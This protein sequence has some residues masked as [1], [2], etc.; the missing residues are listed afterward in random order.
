AGPTGTAPVT[1][2]LPTTPVTGGADLIPAPLKNFGITSPEQIT[3]EII[4][5]FPAEGLALFTPE[6]T[7]ALP[8]ESQAALA[9]RLNAPSTPAAPAEIPEALLIRLK[10]IGEVEIGATGG[11]TVTRVNG[12]AS[13]GLEIS[14]DTTGNTVE[15]VDAVQ[16]EFDAFRARPGNEG[17]SVKI[18]AEQGSQITKSVNAVV[19]EGL[20]GAIVAVVII[21]LFLRSTRSTL[22]TA[23]S[24]PLSIVVALILMRL[25]GFS[26]NVMTL[27]GLTVAVGRVIDDS[28]VV[29]ENIYRHIN[30]GDDLNR[31]VI[32][33]TKEVA[34]AIT[35]STITTVCVFLPL[36]LVGGIVSKFFLPFALTVT[37]ALLAS[38]VV[39]LTVI[40]LLARLFLRRSAKP[41]PEETLLQRWYTAALKWSLRYRGATLVIA[42]ALLLASCAAI[43]L[44]KVTFLP[45]QSEKNITLS[46][47]LPAGTNL[48]ATSAKADEIEALI[49]PLQDQGQVRDIQTVV[50]RA[51]GADRARDRSGGAG[52]SNRA[53]FTLILDNEKVADPITL[54]KQIETQVKA[55]PGVETAAAETIAVGGSAPG[56]GGLDITLVSADVDKLREANDK[57]MAAIGGNKAS[58]RFPVANVKSS[59]AEVKPE[60]QVTVDPQKAIKHGTSAAQIALQ[61]RALLAGERAGD[62]T[63]EGQ[64]QLELFVQVDQSD[65][66]IETLRKLPVGTVSPVALEEVAEIEEV[67]GASSITRINGDRAASISGQFTSDNTFQTQDAIEEEISK[68]IGLPEGVLIQ[69]G[70]QAR[71]QTETFANMGL[72][73]LVAI[74]LVYIVMMI[75]FGSLLNP[76]IIL[77]SVL[78]AIIGVVLSLLLTGKPA[79][80]TTMIGLLMLV[81]IV[82]TNGI[83]LVELVEQYREERGMSAYDA[84]LRAGRVRLRPILMTAIATIVALIP[85]ALGLEEG[86]FIG[87]DLGVVVIGGLFT[88]TFLTLLVVPVVYSLLDGLKTRFGF[89]HKP[90]EHAEGEAA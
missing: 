52:A 41:E 68:N 19:S 27:G 39:A 50:G 88:S 55:L 74:M 28:I 90:A 71:S 89:G 86:G 12:E 40:P 25:Q 44:L 14:R 60:L 21:F 81:G 62:V 5:Q 75:S 15:I 53:D 4:N 34:G 9:Q 11:N 43:P 77:C 73:L 6:L 49:K 46:I 8:A 32:D 13:L 80:I 54:A 57:I 18:V 31:S 51:G 66:D 58:D 10:D 47:S 24:I 38:L 26:L 36:G 48:E 85:L 87:A 2:T 3:P 65:L 20:I 56:T 84:L 45:D 82:V 69:A 35:A 67:P 72:A 63:L 78:M 29:L 33:G 1:G 83:V 64:D 7:A 76:L 17:L 42:G 70:A 23:V 79:G 61:I 30:R 22:I 16:K 59:L 37:Y